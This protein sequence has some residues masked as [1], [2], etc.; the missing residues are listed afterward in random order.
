MKK[1]EHEFTITDFFLGTQN[2]IAV[3]R[4][5]CNCGKK[6]WEEMIRLEMD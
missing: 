1:H 4:T 3:A 2:N 5:E 6:S